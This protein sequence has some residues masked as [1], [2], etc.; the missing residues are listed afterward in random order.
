MPPERP[1]PVAPAADF[2]CR[3]EVD[4]DGPTTVEQDVSGVQVKVQ[5]GPSMDI[6]NGPA[7][8]LQ[9]PTCVLGCED[10]LIRYPMLERR[11]AVAAESER[12]LSTHL[13]G[14]N[15]MHDAFDPSERHER[16]LLLLPCLI[17][18]VCVHIGV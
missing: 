15:E 14:P 4:Y 2:L 8:Q 12:L 18:I 6:R 5:P 11:V 9:D 10:T 17:E 13:D 7:N 16:S 3:A 1:R